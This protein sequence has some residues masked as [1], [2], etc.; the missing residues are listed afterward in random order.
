MS[1]AARKLSV[2]VDHGMCMGVE[3]CVH[4][5][6]MSFVIEGGVA[7]GFAE[8]EDPLE[9]VL[10]AARACPNFAITVLVDGAVAFDPS[11]Q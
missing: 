4:A 11:K 10:E 8:P 3:A 7:R 5:A 6:P 1:G 2:V 9:A